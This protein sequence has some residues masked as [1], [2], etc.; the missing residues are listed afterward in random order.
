[1]T[2]ITEAVYENGVLK[3]QGALRLH[4]QQHVRIIVEPIEDGADRP[5]ALARLK[6]GIAS[7]QFSSSGPLPDREE[8]HDRV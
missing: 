5:A 4:E 6:A 2:Q 7:M 3:P 1:M 8:L